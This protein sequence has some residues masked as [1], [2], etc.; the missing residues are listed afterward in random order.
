MPIK[1]N[2]KIVSYICLFS[3]FSNNVYSMFSEKSTL[4]E[5]V[6]EIIEKE[7]TNEENTQKINFDDMLLNKF[8]LTGI[9]EIYQTPTKSKLMLQE[10]EMPE[11]FKK[12][13]YKELCPE[14]LKELIRGYKKLGADAFSP[15]FAN[16]LPKVVLL[17]GPNGTGKSTLG[18]LIS[19]KLNIKLIFINS[20]FLGTMYRQSEEV[21]LSETI[22]PL[23]E[24]GTPCVIVIDEADALVGKNDK[25]DNSN[26]NKS[27][28]I[29]QMMDMSKKKSNF[30]LVWTTNNIDQIDAKFR[31]RA[32][33]YGRIEIPLPNQNNREKAIKYLQKK[34]TEASNDKIKTV[35]DESPEA[36]I[37][38]AKKT[39]G[40]SFRAIEELHTRSFLK[41]LNRV[42]K[43]TKEEE[44]ENTE[45]IT[46]IVNEN[47]YTTVGEKIANGV[48]DDKNNTSN[49]N[50]IKNIKE[51]GLIGCA[52]T[53]ACAVFG[54][55]ISY[56]ISK[57]SLDHAKKAQK[58][59]LFWTK[60]GVY[61]S[62]IGTTIS[63]AAA[64][65]AIALKIA[66]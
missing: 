55:G 61:V 42:P 30:I 23:L 24:D 3:L 12:F 6:I 37:S 60:I 29:A 46:I 57:Q 47:D 51:Y 16:T 25:D 39:E 15:Q 44:K 45:P 38:I 10:P 66:K 49:K 65:I 26:R 33:V 41:A 9:D 36:I 8:P 59:S 53:F 50:T 14:P 21:N 22:A 17:Y 43:K 19:K 62:T 20:G 27:A 2:K 1:K 35:Y 31:D 11:D 32:G 18:V 7:A 58:E 52:I 28:A 56:I 4:K 63:S 48:A 34:Q 5:E 64:I 13:V 40:L 54:G